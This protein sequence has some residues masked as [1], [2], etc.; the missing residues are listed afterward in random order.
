MKRRVFPRP[1]KRLVRRGNPE[2]LASISLAFDLG[3]GT[4]LKGIDV[5]DG[6]TLRTEYTLVYSPKQDGLVAVHVPTEDGT[7]VETDVRV[8][9]AAHMWLCLACHK[10]FYFGPQPHPHECPGCG[11]SYW[12]RWAMR[13][14]ESGPPTGAIV[15]LRATDPNGFVKQEWVIRSKTGR[16]GLRAEELLIIDRRSGTATT[17]RHVVNQLL[18]DS[19]TWRRVHNE[20]VEYPAKRR[21]ERS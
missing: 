6:E 2:E 14:G 3:D 7:V 10:A 18:H 8:P 15:K 17:K 4:W 1:R 16:D 20:L 13:A 19:D 21:R 11:K 12:A 9:A 5:A